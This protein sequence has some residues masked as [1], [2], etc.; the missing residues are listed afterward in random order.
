MM[1]HFIGNDPVSFE[2][3]WHRNTRFEISPTLHRSVLIVLG[4]LS[5]ATY[6]LTFRCEYYS[7]V[8]IAEEHH[9]MYSKVI[10]KRVD[11]LNEML[12]GLLRSIPAQKETKCR[13]SAVGI[14]G[15][16]LARLAGA[17]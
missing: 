7:D 11:S 6:V 16:P 15:M 5:I 4:I 14:L 12:L 3:L 8:S 2:G 1:V 10:M 17:T 13:D 9:V